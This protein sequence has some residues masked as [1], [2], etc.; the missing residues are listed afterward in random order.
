M[1]SYHH[2]LQHRTS[3]LDSPAKVFAKLKAKVLSEPVCVNQGLLTSNDGLCY[4]R[5]EHRSVLNSPRKKPGSASI[6]DMLKENQKKFDS[7]HNEVQA[8][9]LSPIASPKKHGGYSEISPLEDMGRGRMRRERSFLES[10]AM[11]HVL[12]DRG[13]IQRGPPQI[14][15]DFKVPRG[16]LMNKQS[17]GRRAFEEDRAPL[18][19]PL[20][21]ACTFSP[22]KKRLRKRK[23]EQQE[24]PAVSEHSTR[25]KTKDLSIVEGYSSDSTEMTLEPR[26]PTIRSATEKR[27]NDIVERFPPMSP[28]KI[29]AYM[30][31]REGKKELQKDHVVNRR[32]PFDGGTSHP[33]RD[34]PLTTTH[35]METEDVSSTNSPESAVHANEHGVDSTDSRSETVL[36][37]DATITSAPVILH[38]DPL[39]LESPQISI[40]KKHGEA[41]FRRNQ[42]SRPVKFAKDN[43]IYL[44]KW[45]LRSSYDGLYVNG[46]HGETNIPWKS[47]IVVGRVS[48]S[49]LKTVTGRVYI[50]VGKMKVDL[51]SGL[52]GWF[53]K[54]FAKGFPANWN[55]L[56]EKFLLESKAKRK[57]PGKKVKGRSVSANTQSQT[58]S[59]EC[60]VK[61][62]RTT[63]LRTPDSCLSSTFLSCTKVSRSGRV[64]KPPLEYWKGGRVILDGHMNVKVLQCYETS[65]INDEV[66]KTVSARS[67][68]KPVRVLVPRSEALKQRELVCD[69]DVS[70]PLRRVNIPRH[71][72]NRATVNA[73]EKPSNL[74]KPPEETLCSPGEQSGRRRSSQ[75]LSDKVD[76]DTKKQIEPENSKRKRSKTQ[77]Q[78]TN[79]PPKRPS[80]R[81]KTVPNITETS[82]SD[83]TLHNTSSDDT[84]SVKKKKKAHRVKKGRKIHNKSKLNHESSSSQPSES[85]AD[86]EESTRATK[87]RDK[88]QTKHKRSKCIEASPPKM[89]PPKSTKPKGKHKKTFILPEQDGDE[90][91][92]AELKKLKE[93]VSYYPKHMDGYW[94]EVARMVGTR[95]AEECHKQHTSQGAS[96]TPAVKPK[97]PKKKKVEPEVPV[98]DKPVIS[99]RVGTLR[100]KQQVREFLEAM[101]KEDVDDVFSSAYMRNKRFEMPSLL[102]GDDH[103]LRVSDQIPTT[104][105]SSY[106]PEVKT[107]Q[108]LHITPGMMGSPD[109]NND[110]K[111]V[112]Q[113]QKR[114]KKNQFNVC[115]R[116]TTSK[117]FTPTPS[118]KRSMRR[119]GNAEN[120][121]F[122]I[123]E[124]FSGNEEA[125][126]Q[127]GEEEDFY[128]SDDDN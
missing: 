58:S 61:R 21:P 105:S 39:V 103:D 122:V 14:R 82:D 118:V 119:C 13:Q 9:T 17:D 66:A 15:D 4:S 33:S 126:S 41:V 114:M 88:A 116:P 121:S 96:Q 50:L 125:P 101:P 19:T 100:R 49:V 46:I 108:C 107:P 68:Q 55:E 104:P 52:P 16:T 124:M 71:K 98:T 43:V 70:I 91:T 123:W 113:L 56:Y 32:V 22:M 40:P 72:P 106:F 35:I 26:L 11:S 86:S 28:A 12:C 87:K 45:Y 29:F 127:S 76:T 128:F 51:E 81:K 90:W 65:I 6:T 102:P 1:A 30:K 7:H 59:L 48:S 73:E 31:E 5:D 77:T 92:T 42:C 79:K 111:Y 115:K 69:K 25:N 93:A 75:R 24:S 78:D 8:L 37:E 95:S 110:D 117:S 109:R 112:Y 27:H 89:P 23:W 34:T 74:S 3:R 57:E 64:I 94:A 97:M 85:P 44:S 20:Y 67:S 84:G 62:H 53:L 36:G 54:K 99:A 38:Q 80:R 18:S 63:S 2:L 60:S 120:S 47:N 83:K 10:T